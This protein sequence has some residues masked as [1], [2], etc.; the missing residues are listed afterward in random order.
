MKVYMAVTADEYEL[1]VAVVDSAAELAE[2]YGMTK[3]SVLSALTRESQRKNTK[4]KFIRLEI[5]ED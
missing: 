4:R 1:P 2:I 5:E 3:G